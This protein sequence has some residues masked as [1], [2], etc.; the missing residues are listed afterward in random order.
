M[1]KYIILFC[2]AALFLSLIFLETGDK[3]LM[4][5]ASMPEPSCPA[6]GFPLSDAE[7][8]ELAR[9]AAQ[10]AIDQEITKEEYRSAAE[11]LIKEVSPELI[12]GYNGI[13]CG[14]VGYARNDLPWDAKAFVKRHELEHLLQ[15]GRETKPE[16]RANLAGFKEYPMGAV[17]TLIFTLN[18]RTKYYDSPI[19]Y[20]L[21]LWKLA[22]IYLLPW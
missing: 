14:N 16:F 12:G 10:R 2:C 17:R 4:C 19:C 11:I 13:A 22:K 5:Q 3:I 1:K 7:R 18:T 6:A 9:L 20:G 15:T 8:V 21:S